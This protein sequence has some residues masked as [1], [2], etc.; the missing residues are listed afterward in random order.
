MTRMDASGVQ[1]YSSPSS[2]PE[3]DTTLPIPLEALKG[4]TVVIT[5]GA[6]GIGASI[7]IKVAENG[8]QVLIG[9]IN[10]T[11]GEEVVAYIRQSYKSD[12]HHF[13]HLDVTSWQSQTAFFKQAASLSIHGGIDAVIANAGIA[14]HK[15]QQKFENPPDYSKLESP[16]QPPYRTFQVNALG[17][18]YTSELA[19]S[20]LSRNPQSSKCSLT[21]SEGPRDRH[22]LLVSSIAGVAAVPNI[23][24]YAAA[25][26]AVV[27]L[28]RSLRMTAPT[29]TGVRVNMINP[30]FTDTPILG[31]EGPLVMAGAGMASITDVTNAAV[32]LIA[33]K[34]IIGRAL[35]IVSRG[36]KEQVQAAGIDWKEGDKHGNAVR[37]F[38]GRDW[39]QTDVFTRRMVGITNLVSASRG[40]V[41]WLA[42]VIAFFVHAL[43]KLM[44]R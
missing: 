28:F 24:T 13:V 20:Y 41:G 37:D 25:K 8:G 31:P 9:D 42:D 39:E 40:W 26:H 22:L 17:V 15:E 14:D 21:P 27:G 2:S 10:T 32:R 23:P 43:L 38:A 5:G 16:P 18:L 33:D 44:G 1:P 34:A 12:S 3:V 7:A 6:S 4:R 11:L 30:Y 36:T 19:L 29:V 35:M